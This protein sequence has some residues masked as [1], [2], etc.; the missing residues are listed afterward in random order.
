MSRKLLGSVSAVVLL[1]A[2]TQGARAGMDSQNAVFDL[3]ANVPDVCTLGDFTETSSNNVTFSGAGGS[4]TIEIPNPVDVN[5]N[6][7]DF[8]L[9]AEASAMCNYGDADIELTSSNDGMTGPGAVPGFEN[10]ID[11]DA[12]VDLNGTSF[13]LNAADGDASPAA[14]S[15]LDIGPFTGTIE[16]TISNANNDGPYLAG[17]YSD[18]LTLEIGSI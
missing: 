15:S 18:T 10:V 17:A 3:E 5:A 16:L 13:T 4:Y 6:L 11:Y 1:L 8:E 9:V 7:Q 2:A 14:A 12:T